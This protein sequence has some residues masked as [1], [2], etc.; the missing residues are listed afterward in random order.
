MG[1]LSLGHYVVGVGGLA[2]LRSYF[3]GDRERANHLIGELTRLVTHPDQPP[4][5]I[6]LDVPELDV[7]AGYARWAATY[8]SQ[9]NP[10][11]RL[12]EPLVR[13]L[14]DSRAPGDALDAAC[15]TGRHTAYLQA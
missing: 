3:T 6:E 5:S 12:E 15:G 4:M 1:R 13:A 9:P 14:I 2:V 8:D 7:E 11:I 10:L